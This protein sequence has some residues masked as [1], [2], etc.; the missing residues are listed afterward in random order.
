MILRGKTSFSCNDRHAI[1]LHEDELLF[2]S[3]VCTV[4]E[5]RWCPAILSIDWPYRSFPRLALMRVTNWSF[6]N[7]TYVL[8]E[9][10]LKDYPNPNMSPHRRGSSILGGCLRIQTAMSPSKEY[11][12][13]FVECGGVLQNRKLGRGTRRRVLRR[14]SSMV[15]T[16]E[17]E[18]C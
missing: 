2:P 14:M 13:N 5:L 9:G 6:A 10:I 15:Q 18:E 11:R 8:A 12:W 1:N 17:L 4:E 3:T 16:I 7:S